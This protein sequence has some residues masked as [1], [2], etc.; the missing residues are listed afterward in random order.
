M[1]SIDRWRRGFRQYDV[2]GKA[3]RHLALLE[4]RVFDLRNRTDTS[5]RVELN[6][7]TFSSPAKRQGTLYIPTRVRAL[8]YFLN[9]CDFPS[10]SVFVDLGCGKGQTL[11]VASRFPFKRVV[12]IEYTRELCTIATA[13]V[14]AYR[15]QHP[16]VVSIDVI[17]AD[18]AEYEVKPDENVFYMYHPFGPN[19]LRQVVLNILSS[20]ERHSRPVWIVYCHPLYGDVIESCGGEVGSAGT[21]VRVRTFRYALKEFAVYGLR[22]ARAA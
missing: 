9:T 21:F 19:V 11:L 18:A 2:R 8:R 10:A 3:E 6:A 5:G 1:K 13:N 22:H 14:Q 7:L 16:A 20:V 12:G 17:E 15:K 4:D